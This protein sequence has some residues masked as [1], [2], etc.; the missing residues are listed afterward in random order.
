MVPVALVTDRGA[1]HEM[2]P[3]LP[4]ITEPTLMMIDGGLE[5]GSFSYQGLTV[6][7]AESPAVRCCQGFLRMRLISLELCLNQAVIFS[8]LIKT[9]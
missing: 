6:T 5:A 1:W 2:L 7:R 4:F 3:H 9:L 8:K